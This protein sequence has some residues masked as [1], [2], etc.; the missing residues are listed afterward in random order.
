ML[1]P[2]IGATQLTPYQRCFFK[3]ND[4]LLGKRVVAISVPD[5]S[6]QFAGITLV[7]PGAYPSLMLTMCDKENFEQI[8][9]MPLME[10]Y[11]GTTSGGNT[12]KTRVFDF[13]C[14]IENCYL[15]SSQTFVAVGGLVPTLAIDI[16][17]RND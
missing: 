8:K 15:I 9:N 2:V 16:F 17:T 6:A 10:L 12:G 14:E 5:G 11:N 7:P 3:N 1:D 13:D 4:K